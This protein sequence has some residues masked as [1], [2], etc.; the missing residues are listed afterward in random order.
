MKTREQLLDAAIDLF[1]SKGFTSTSMKDLAAAAG[2]RAPAIYNHFSSKERILAAA[3]VWALEDFKHHVIDTD[4]PA[5][6]PVARL[7]NLVRKHVTYQLEHSKMV[8]S[9]DTL[10]ES[11]AL[12]EILTPE[13]QAEIRVFIR[14]YRDLMTQVIDAVRAQTG[15]EFPSTGLCVLAILNLCDQSRSWFRVDGEL[16]IEEVKDGYWSLIAGMLRLV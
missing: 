2:V 3:L 16:S 9:A 10:L 1:G 13:D 8:R 14:R 6:E 5:G 11:V 7:E 15:A 4:D 12:G